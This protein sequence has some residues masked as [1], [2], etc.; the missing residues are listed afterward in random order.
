[1]EF[2]I[3]TAWDAIDSI[4]QFA[5]EQV[6]VANVPPE[7]RQLMVEFDATAKHYEMV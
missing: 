5:G 6:N 2:L 4:K 7:A 3:V 1:M